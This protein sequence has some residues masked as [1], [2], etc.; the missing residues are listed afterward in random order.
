MPHESESEIGI[1]TRIL[2]QHGASEVYIFG[3]RA[4]GTAGAH[5]DLDLAVRGMPPEHYF[6]AVGETCPALCIPVD[7]L[8]LD[9]AGPALDYLKEH[10]NLHRVA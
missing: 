1:A 10:G 5:S 6:L 3:S 9:E 4:Q 8:D 7:I 2:L